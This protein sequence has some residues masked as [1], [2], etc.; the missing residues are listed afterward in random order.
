LSTGQIG[1]KVIVLDVVDSTLEEAKRLGDT[2]EGT[3]VVAR[4]QSSGKGRFGRRWF[5]PLGGLWFTVILYPRQSATS[6]PLLSLTASLAV[7]KGITKTTGL[8]AA[9][10]WPNDVYVH[11][12]K[13]AGV[14]TEM[15]IVGDTI[16]RAFVG[17]G[18]NAN[19]NVEELPEEAREMATT[20]MRELGSKVDVEKLLTDILSEF[21]RLYEVYKTGW[22]DELLKEIRDS[23][24]LL[25]APVIVALPNGTLIGILE[26]VDELGRIVLRLDQDRIQL[27][28]GDIERISPA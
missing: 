27:S 3:V 25:G 14:L 9:I 15:E 18:V 2:E 20:L 24:E 11:G 5:S 28:P 7:S 8:S 23:M 4:E 6:S 10:R 1:S 26:N 22:R 16:T 12:G 17:I 13:V 21:E 19:F